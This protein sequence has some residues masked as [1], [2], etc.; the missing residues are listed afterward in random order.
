MVENKDHENYLAHAHPHYYFRVL[1]I[2]RS[3]KRNRFSYFYFCTSVPYINTSS[4][5][6]LQHL[7]TCWDWLTLWCQWHGG[8]VCTHEYLCEIGTLYVKIRIW[9]PEGLE[10]WKTGIQMFY[11]LM[12]Y[13]RKFLIF[14]PKTRSDITQNVQQGA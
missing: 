4:F 14:A 5:S 10:S 3:D 1:C 13:M 7:R 11:Y 8:I 6:Y 12:L 9:G 2:C